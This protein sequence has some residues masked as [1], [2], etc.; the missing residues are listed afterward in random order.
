MT[1]CDTLSHPII[2]LSRG[3]MR[4]ATLVLGRLTGAL[5]VVTGVAF[6][7]LTLSGSDLHENG[8]RLIAANAPWVGPLSLVAGTLGVLGGI[9]ERRRRA[10]GGTL[11][12]LCLAC[13]L[14]NLGSVT[15]GS[16]GV[17]NRRYVIALFAVS[18]IV[19][20]LA[21]VG[22]IAGRRHRRMGVTLL[23]LC[24]GGILL[25]IVVSTLFGGALIIL[26]FAVPIIALV[27]ALIFT[28]RRSPPVRA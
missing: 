4:N 19:G 14:F 24:L 18:S 3:S 17:D 12:S 20:A 5:L 9:V 22:V 7:I 15:L 2:G 8:V 23:S 1:G 11:L 28:A 13:T 16:Y 27:L 6:T 26:I 10:L 21:V 25:F